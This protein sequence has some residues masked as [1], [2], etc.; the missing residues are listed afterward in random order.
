MGLEVQ[1]WKGGGVGSACPPS[2]ST[3]LRVLQPSVG[4]DVREA[5]V[6]WPGKQAMPLSPL[7]KA[8]ALRLVDYVIITQQRLNSAAIQ[9]SG[10]TQQYGWCALHSV[11]TLW[12]K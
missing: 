4:M 10:N 6:V 2:L 1:A 5:S 3:A 11:M 12:K 7:S 8:E 9:L